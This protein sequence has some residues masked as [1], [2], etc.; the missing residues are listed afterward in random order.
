MWHIVTD[1]KNTTEEDINNV[2]FGNSLVNNFNWADGRVEPVNLA[3]ARTLALQDDVN[4][5]FLA[6]PESPNAGEDA[7]APFDTP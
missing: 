7:A 5:A 1:A 3:S 6:M 4:A 2:F